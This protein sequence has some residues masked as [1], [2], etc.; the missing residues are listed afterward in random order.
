MW[1]L[2]L[3]RVGCGRR[4]ESLPPMKGSHVPESHTVLFRSWLLGR[5]QLPGG[6][7]QEGNPRT[8]SPTLGCTF[9]PLP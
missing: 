5:L 8:T 9:K 2:V 1:R 4:S 6:K 7:G 3:R